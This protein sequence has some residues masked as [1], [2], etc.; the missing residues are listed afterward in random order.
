MPISIH[1]V[2]FL[3]I[4]ILT[5]DFTVQNKLFYIIIKENRGNEYEKGFWDYSK[6]SINKE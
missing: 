2:N 4:S 1:I 5:V 3:Y 6:R